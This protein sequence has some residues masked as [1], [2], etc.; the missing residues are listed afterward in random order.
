MAMVE[1][2]VGVAFVAGGVAAMLHTVEK[3]SIGVSNY[4]RAREAREVAITASGATPRRADK[5][6]DPKNYLRRLSPELAQMAD[7][8]AKIKT[9]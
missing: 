4:A 3:Q 9:R 8:D 5:T 1:V 6:F 2:A 7:A